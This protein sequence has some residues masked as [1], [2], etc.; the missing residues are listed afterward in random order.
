MTGTVRINRG[1]LWASLME[2]K[3][4]GAYDG[5]H[6]PPIASRHDAGLVGALAVVEA[7][8]MCE[9]GD[10]A[11]PRATVGNFDIGRGQTNV[12][13]HGCDPSIY[14]TKI[15]ADQARTMKEHCMIIWVS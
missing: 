8:R 13:P 4:I 15:T 1:R 12:I 3:D 5:H 10:F 7:R 14:Q 2:L 9:S 6:P 11:R